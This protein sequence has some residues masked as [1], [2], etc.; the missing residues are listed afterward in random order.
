MLAHIVNSH[1]VEQIE[2]LKVE[3]RILRS[4][5]GWRVR[6]TPE[7]RAQLL[8]FGKPLGPAL[9][10]IISIVRYETFRN[11][12][13]GYIYKGNGK[14]GR[15]AIP[16]EIRQLIIRMALNDRSWGYKK[17]LG[18]LKKLGIEV[19]RSTIQNILR[20]AGL[21]PQPDRKYSS[22]RKFIDQ[23]INTLIACDFFTKEIWT[24]RGRV[25]MYIFFF[26]ELPTRRIHLAGITRYPNQKWVERR[27]KE[28]L[29]IM[30]ESG[31]QPK[32]LIRDRDGK[33]SEDF[34][35]IM[36]DHGIEVK[37]TP[38]RMPLCNVYSERAVQSIKI[39]ALNHF[40]VF[41]KRHLEYLTSS[42]FDYYNNFRPHQGVGNVPI[43]ETSLA[44]PDGEIECVSVLGGLLHHYRRK[45]A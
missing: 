44:P 42:Y 14:V 8:R 27:A 19:A 43:N 39:E 20:E 33:F 1:L 26:I 21:E 37:K 4:K 38:V 45:A 13:R 10:D 29:D 22:W 5:L 15:P 18:E 34:D 40:V 7:E 25:T 6:V 36:N 17:I 32:Y 30:D 2:Y 12:V 41:G 9:K 3:N 35:K 28:V 23:H 24:L 31:F 16:E 11:W